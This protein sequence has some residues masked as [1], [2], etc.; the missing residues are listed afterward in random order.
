MSGRRVVY[1]YAE[2]LYEVAEEAGALP[3]IDSDVAGI[4]K[5]MSEP[6]IKDFC[7]R[8]SSSAESRKLFLQT[9]VLPFISSDLMKNF[10]DTVRENN[11]EALLPYLPEVY[12]EICNE[13]KKII[14]VTAEF[15]SEPNEKVLAVLEKKLKKRLNCDI[16]LVVRVNESLIQGFRVIWKNRLLDRSAAGQLR[17]LRKVLLK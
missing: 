3:E 14:T 7:L 15:A 2:A 4:S 16:E 17:Q 10:I 6:A 8:A 12:H 5:I 11:R 9:A 13:H 1:R